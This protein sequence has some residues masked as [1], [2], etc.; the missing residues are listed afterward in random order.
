MT[1]MSFF[2]QPLIVPAFLAGILF[3]GAIAAWA[4]SLKLRGRLCPQC[5]STTVAL[6][7]GFPLRLL[8][9][10]L[11]KRWCTGCGWRGL[12]FRPAHERAGKGGE[13]RLNGSFKWGAAPPPPDGFFD[14]SGDEMG[15]SG[16][17][18]A[19][20]DP[21]G[22]ELPLPGF[23]WRDQPRIS[24]DAAFNWA[25]DEGPPPIPFKFAE[26]PEPHQVEQEEAE[27]PPRRVMPN[28]GFRWRG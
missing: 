28:L 3:S 10:N 15:R 20:A 17:P 26:T 2:S 22:P 16:S 25:Q 4:R 21:E 7:P 5:A 23:E 12:A 27:P 6:F 11:V 9:S 14:W 8:G 1:S 19:E 18:P 13:V 24:E